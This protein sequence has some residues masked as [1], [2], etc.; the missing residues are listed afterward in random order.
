MDSIF[1]QRTGMV[2]LPVLTIKLF[3][4]A[5]RRICRKISTVVRGTLY[6]AANLVGLKRAPNGKWDYKNAL[7]AIWIFV[8]GIPFIML[9]VGPELFSASIWFL[10]VVTITA[11]FNLEDGLELTSHIMEHGLHGVCSSENG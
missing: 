9:F 5:I 7:T 8:G 6:V 2:A 1:L 10:T 3:N 11:L 4:K